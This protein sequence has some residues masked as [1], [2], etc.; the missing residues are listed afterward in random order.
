MTC[1]LIQISDIHW[2]GI[3]RHKE[4]TEIF[5]KLFEEIRNEGN[6]D[7]VVLTGDIFHTKTHGI[8]PEVID[9]MVWM[10]RG[11]ASLCPL[12]VTLGNHDGNLTNES[13]QDVISP[14]IEA[15]NDP[16][17]YFMKQSGNYPLVSKG[18][19]L[20]N[21][22]NFSCF[23]E[24]GWSKVSPRSNGLP[25]IALFHGSVQGCVVGDGFLLES[26]VEPS[27]F[28]G[29]DFCMLGDIHKRQ[30]L[31]TRPDVD[32]IEKPWM[33][34][35]GSLIQQNFGEEVEKGFLIWDIR[36]KND[37]DVTFRQ[38]KNK[39]AF[40]TYPW[41]NSLE[42]TMENLIE[43]FEDDP[44]AEKR[45]RIKSTSKI[46]SLEK[47]KI[48]STLTGLGA[49][50]AIVD[51]GKTNKITTVETGTVSVHKASLR[52][53]ET[54]LTTLFEEY[55]LNNPK[56]TLSE[57]EKAKA[58]KLLVSYM[59]KVNEIDIENPV[60]DVVW[61][62]KNLEFSNLYKYDEGNEINFEKLKGITY[63]AGNNRVGK[64]S[65]IG[66]IIY[67]LFNTT[68][69][70]P[71]KSY[72]IINKTKKEA[73]ARA[74]F[75]VNQHDYI[76]VRKTT[77]KGKDEEEKASTNLNFYKV[78]G[79]E[80]IEITNK[81]DD[82]R[83]DTDKNIRKLIGSA[84]DFILTSFA[85]ENSLNEYIGQGATQRKEILNK[86]LDLDVFNLLYKLANTDLAV[87]K[88]KTATFSKGDAE[89]MIV[90]LRNEIQETEKTIVSLEGEI[91]TLQDRK[92][93]LNSSGDF[94]EA[95]RILD[96]KKK[97]EL[98]VSTLSSE[99]KT[100]EN[101][102]STIKLECQRYEEGIS[103]LKEKINSYDQEALEEEKQKVL[104]LSEKCNSYKEQ[105][106][107]EKTRLEAQKKSLRR[108]EVVPCGDNFPSCGFIKDS[109]ES[110]GLVGGQEKL[111][112]E[113]LAAF[114]E[115]ER[116]LLELKQRKAETALQELL[117]GKTK[118]T[119]A[120]AI[121]KEKQKRL[122]MFESQVKTQR[123]NLETK[124]EE[125]EVAEARKLEIEQ[126]LILKEKLVE[127]NKE[128][129]QK[130]SELRACYVS[131]GSLKTK[132]TNIETER[133]LVKKLIEEQRVLDSVSQA[134][135]K[136]GI[137]A[138]ILKSQLPQLNEEINSIL[139][140]VVDFK[141]SLV[142][143]TNSNTLDIFIEDNHS[144]RIIELA[145]G[146][147]K[148]LTSLALRVALYNL[149][150]LPK[151]DMFLIDEGFGALDPTSIAKCMEFLSLLKTKFR[152]ILII[153]H[154]P[155]V[156]EIADTV[157]EIQ[158]TKDLHS[159]VVLV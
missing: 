34:Y 63:I 122:V 10:F 129:A 146:M 154:Q 22:G 23:D 91:L 80:E 75:S 37:W 73:T 109:H 68:D 106:S 155:Q 157:L 93:E 92:S 83:T 40:V 11:L 126:D 14:I 110:K 54:V 7:A 138:L 141:I 66:S 116:D 130:E 2:L 136:N 85:N 101:N 55:L 133:D 25:N 156:K 90:K 56:I 67:S 53:D 111:V 76:A 95:Q 61:S 21:I 149:T 132:L 71:V 78:E 52:N 59:K 127:V 47:R 38:I 134:F 87:I 96:L 152:F 17:I 102:I 13:R 100:T 79:E 143:E 9:K 44:V 145:S 57:D 5:E 42:E 112:N 6:I 49:L 28:D 88:T 12:Y 139:S 30:D 41:N 121:L 1:K 77:K 39:H 108:L 69:R 144:R 29:F 48:C 98:E 20:A 124:K 19:K 158:E 118:L 104:E 18:K 153:A 4:Y 128:L 74:I 81:N 137:P 27:L 97:L 51:D 84:Q 148:T 105:L 24:E 123:S 65:I 60:R 113:L 142:T 8:T 89:S 150:S 82:T 147:E 131:T 33:S 117:T 103:K 50:E 43:Y 46:S 86:F 58:K 64:S 114:Q 125:L 35:P 36:D 119:S 107:V 62:L 151:S 70:G 140:G 99:V 159:H 120:E 16:N 115:V 3:E 15:M 94:R 45:V 135:N 31:K 26:E 32:G 72:H